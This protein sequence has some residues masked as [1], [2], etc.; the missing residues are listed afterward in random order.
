MTIHEAKKSLWASLKENEN[1][2]GCGI[3]K[4]QDGEFIQLML[5]TEDLN[6]QTY[7]GHR[8]KTEITG[9]LYAQTL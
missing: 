4:D 2:V 8:V 5:A 1:V 9:R 7:E 6:I 3:S